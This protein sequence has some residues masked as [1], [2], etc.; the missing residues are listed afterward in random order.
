MDNHF[1]IMLKENDTS[2]LKLLTEKINEG[3]YVNE[4][5]EVGRSTVIIL[6]KPEERRNRNNRY[7]DLIERAVENEMVY[8]SSTLASIAP[9]AEQTEPSSGS[10][11]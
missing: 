11:V 5:I 10:G 1:T 3:F 7:A 2:N 9:V 4:R 6:R 8:G